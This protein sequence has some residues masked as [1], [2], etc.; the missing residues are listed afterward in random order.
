[1]DAAFDRLRRYSRH[2]NQRLSQVARRLVDGD[3][4]PDTLTSTT[5]RR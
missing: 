4:D 5:Q 1:M 2:H 3:L